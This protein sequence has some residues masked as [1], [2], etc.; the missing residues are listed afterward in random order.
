MNTMELV[1]AIFAC[2]IVGR[3][4]VCA[5]LIIGCVAGY[6]GCGHMAKVD[7]A[8]AKAARNTRYN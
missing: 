8:A 2:G 6:I 3:A 1:Q 7:E 5:P 4:V